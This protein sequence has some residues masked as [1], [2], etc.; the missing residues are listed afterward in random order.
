[1]RSDLRTS[2]ASKLLLQI[3]ADDLHPAARD[4]DATGR[5]TELFAVE[6]VGFR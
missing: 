5:L 4:D 6:I 2:R 3:P 1:M